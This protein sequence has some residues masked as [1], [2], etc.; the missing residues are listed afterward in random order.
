[1]D[2]LMARSTVSDQL[3]QG[4]PFPICSRGLTVSELPLHGIFRLQGN[5]KDA[6]FGAAVTAALDLPLPV[7]EGFSVSG[8]AQLAWAGPNEFLYFCQLSSEEIALSALIAALAGQFATVTQV[9]DSRVAFIFSGDDA[10]AFLAKG[11]AIDLN[12]VA[13]P[14]GHVVTTR[15]AGLPSM[16]MHRTVGEYVAYF[17]VG[18]AAYVL[19][20]MLDAAEEFRDDLSA[21]LQ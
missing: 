7:S 16:L 12:P 1:M 9:S 8:N 13:F 19:S 14:A 3:V 2:K 11:C 20:W 4:R 18:S 10:P 5:A 17:D 21:G 6:A 15:F